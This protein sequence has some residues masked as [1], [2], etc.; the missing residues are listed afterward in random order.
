MPEFSG[1]WGDFVPLDSVIGDVGSGVMSGRTWVIASDVATLEARWT[2]LLSESDPA[3]KELLFH[4]QLRK[5]CLG[6][7]AHQE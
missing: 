6:I 3:R 4:P 7:R 1:G 2:A 5:G